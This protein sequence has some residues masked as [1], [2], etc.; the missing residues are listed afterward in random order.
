[1]DIG[2]K[3]KIEVDG[4]SKEAELLRIA[5]IDNN[6]YAIYAIDN[7]N[8]TSD[9]FASKIVK[10]PNNEDTLVDLDDNERTKLT[11]VIQAMFS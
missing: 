8:D 2:D 4:T 6:D 9:I 11:E 10:N 7:G 1:M 3:F 5:T